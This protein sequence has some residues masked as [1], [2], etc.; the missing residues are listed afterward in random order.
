MEARRE[1]CHIFQVLEEN[2]YQQR[3]VFLGQIYFR[4]KGDIAR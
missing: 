4:K 2:T 1:W 3:I